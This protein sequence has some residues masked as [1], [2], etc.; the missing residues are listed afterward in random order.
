MDVIRPSGSKTAS[1]GAV[2]ATPATT[3]AFDVARAS[4][5]RWQEAVR[6]AVTS[7][8]PLVL[9]IGPAEDPGDACTVRGYPLGPG[10]G[11]IVGLATTVSDKEMANEAQ[12]AAGLG[13]AQYD[14]LTGT[15]WASA[16]FG[17]MLGLGA[18][19]WY[20]PAR[21]GALTTG[22]LPAALHEL[23]LGLQT[24][25]QA[26]AQTRIADGKEVSLAAEGLYPPQGAPLLGARLIVQDITELESS[27]QRAQHDHFVARRLQEAVQPRAAFSGRAVGLRT[28][29]HYR[30]AEGRVGGDWYKVRALPGEL[31]LLAV[32]D[33]RG[34]GLDAV[35]LMSKLR[36]A[37]AGLAFTGARVEELT[38]WLNEITYD[39]GLE[40]TATTL[41]ARYHPHHHLLRWTC[42]GHP[43]PVRLR[44]GRAELLDPLTGPPLGTLQKMSYHAVETVMEMDDIVLLYTDGLVERRDEDLGERLEVLLDA[45]TQA[46]SHRNLDEL[47]RVIGAAMSGPASEDDA[48]LL[49]IQRVPPHNPSLPTG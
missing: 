14:I 46:S 13:W 7:G 33:A 17:R 45:A 20:R 12:R 48:T 6:D 5:E 39:D 38:A 15:L 37:L 19:G 29:V 1:V 9:P 28:A 10:L 40:S 3:A 2:H 35:S 27:Q 18:E 42:A 47:V 23:L 24:S 44:R 16:G 31:A 49:A 8:R 43:P 30:P 11:G 36:H 26:R 21:Q 41:I 32:G 25:S 4:G 22:S 34:H